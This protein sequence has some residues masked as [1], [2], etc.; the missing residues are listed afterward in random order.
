MGNWITTSYT[1]GRLARRSLSP[2]VFILVM[3]VLNAMIYKAFDS[4]GFLHLN[5][6]ALQHR[7]SFYADDLVLFLSPVW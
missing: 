4:D 3:D 6:R 5:D 1:V 7:A 2:M